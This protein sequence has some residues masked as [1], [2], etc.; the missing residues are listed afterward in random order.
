MKQ[1]KDQTLEKM[2]EAIGDISP[3]GEKATKIRK[4]E[5]LD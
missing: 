5:D 1:K 3:K 2:L 4:P